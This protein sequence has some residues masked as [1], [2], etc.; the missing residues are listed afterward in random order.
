MISISRAGPALLLV[1]LVL[2][3]ASSS[4]QEASDE[5]RLSLGRQ[6]FLERAEPQCA[7]CHTLAD[8]GASGAVGPNLDSLQPSYDQVKNAVVNGVGPMRPYV[9]LDEELDAVAHYVSEAAGN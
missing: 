9:D 7:I 1:V 3:P 5:E 4:A 2:A 8:A 6:V